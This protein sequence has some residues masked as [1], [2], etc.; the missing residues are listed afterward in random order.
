M[1]VGVE[2]YMSNF[3]F[4]NLN[5]STNSLNSSLLFIKQIAMYGQGLMYHPWEL[6]VSLSTCGYD[7]ICRIG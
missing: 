6:T 3:S 2:R 5:L 1:G 7:H 4:S